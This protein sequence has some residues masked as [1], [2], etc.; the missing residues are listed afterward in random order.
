MNHE[1]Y[2]ALVANYTDIP[3]TADFS[4]LAHIS[5]LPYVEAATMDRRMR[6]YCAVAARKIMRFGSAVNYA[7]RLYRDV[8]DFMQRHP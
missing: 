7:D 1:A 3:E 8:G 2:R 6:H 5:A 4:D